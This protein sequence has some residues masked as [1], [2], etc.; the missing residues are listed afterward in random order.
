MKYLNP[1]LLLF[2]FSLLQ[3]E[4]VEQ[5]RKEDLAN[6]YSKEDGL[7]LRDELAYR[8]YDHPTPQASPNPNALN[9]PNEEKNTQVEQSQQNSSLQTDEK[10]NFHI[11]QLMLSG[12][13]SRLFGKY[14]GISLGLTYRYNPSHWGL[15]ICYFESSSYS[16][17]HIRQ[18]IASITPF[19]KIN[20]NPINLYIGTGLGTSKNK[21]SYFLS[22]STE[23][24]RWPQILPS[25]TYYSLDV[26]GLLQVDYS[27]SMKYLKSIGI[28][29]RAAQPSYSLSHQ[30]STKKFQ[31][32]Y[33]SA[34]F[35]LLLGF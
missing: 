20:T 7:P 23:P 28:I 4:E 27:L 29:I 16:G 21:F 25:E 13:Y 12:G 8:I 31:P 17:G 2:C 15:D 19:F 10:P 14:S 18:N 6:T 1:I 3:A 33:P 22:D 32:I 5:T 9:L 30:G 11:H 24:L 26:T 35:G 34:T